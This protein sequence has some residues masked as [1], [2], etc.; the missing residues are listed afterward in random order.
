MITQPRY[1][2]IDENM[3]KFKFV[4]IDK[5]AT[6]DR[7]TTKINIVSRLFSHVFRNSSYDTA[8]SLRLY[9]F[10]VEKMRDLPFRREFSSVQIDL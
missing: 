2:C 1:F 5:S 3:L 9:A 10:C 6:N 7:I 4:L 8:L